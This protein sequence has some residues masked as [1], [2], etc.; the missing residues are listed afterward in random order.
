MGARLQWGSLRRCQGDRTTLC[1]ERG[2][3]YIKPY[4]CCGRRWALGLRCLYSIS[5][6]VFNCAFRSNLENQN[7]ATLV[8]GRAWRLPGLLEPLWALLLLAQTLQPNRETHSGCWTLKTAQGGCVKTW[9]LGGEKHIS[10]LT[11]LL[12]TQMNQYVLLGCRE[13]WWTHEEVCPIAVRWRIIALPQTKVYKTFVVLQ[14]SQEKKMSKTGAG[15]IY[16]CN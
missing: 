4:R 8:E 12:G 13:W 3:E 6:W 9:V 15:G 16:T 10:T 14:R 2:S 11:F 1:S 7:W 5:D